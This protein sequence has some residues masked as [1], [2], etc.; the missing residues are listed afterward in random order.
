MRTHRAYST[1]RRSH[2]PTWPIPGSRSMSRL[3]GSS[4]PSTARSRPPR[5]GQ[6]PECGRLRRQSGAYSA[7]SERRSSGPAYPWIDVWTQASLS[8]GRRAVRTHLLALTL[9]GTKYS[10]AIWPLS[11]PRAIRT[12]TSLLRSVTVP[13]RVVSTLGCG[14]PR[15][16]QRCSLKRDSSAHHGSPELPSRHPFFDAVR[17]K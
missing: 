10:A 8:P 13:T 5:G 16:T 4:S 11:R 2:C 3:F 7:A 6:R 9:Q 1:A 14:L 17:W 12:S 15:R